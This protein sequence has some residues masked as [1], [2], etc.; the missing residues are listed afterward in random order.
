MNEG[1]CFFL[2]SLRWL[3]LW[4]SGP[5]HFLYADDKTRDRFFE[6]APVAW[7]AY[8]STY[9]GTSF[10]ST[11]K[12][13][14][15]L[16]GNVENYERR[17]EVFQTSGRVRVDGND[18]GR[19]HYYFIA[20][21]SYQARLSRRDTGYQLDSAKQISEILS[22]TAL[23]LSYCDAR[24]GLCFF[25]SCIVDSI[26][27][28]PSFHN[29]DDCISFVL[30][31]ADTVTESGQELVQIELAGATRSKDGTFEI[32]QG[33]QGDVVRFSI[34]LNP[35]KNW[36]V[37]RYSSESQVTYGGEKVKVHQQGQLEYLLDS[38]H[39]LK[40][41]ETM[42]FGL[43]KSLTEWIN[44]ELRSASPEKSQFF[45]AGFGLPEPA[46]YQDHNRMKAYTVF[47]ASTGVLTFILIGAYFKR[48]NSRPN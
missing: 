11:I 5:S 39:P 16:S 47:F 43:R 30:E 45:I 14:I 25:D 24:P 35:S 19:G 36:R 28:L 22:P 27:E 1:T 10:D 33:P 15:E 8:D 17:H 29:R 9:V 38:C 26:A 4:I 31:D 21:E 7:A 3:A 41:I 13:A 34:I 40:K 2:F 6:E 23:W 32:F 42:Q 20:N 37:E 12:E 46:W 48:R 44:S 18:V